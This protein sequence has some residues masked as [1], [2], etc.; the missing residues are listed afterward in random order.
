MSKIYHNRS[1][2]NISSVR[3]KGNIGKAY[4]PGEL[5]KRLQ[6]AFWGPKKI[7]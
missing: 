5:N 2:D 3:A 6:L 7:V 1:I 4:E